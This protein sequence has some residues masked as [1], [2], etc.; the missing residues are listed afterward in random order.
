MSPAASCL[1]VISFALCCGGKVENQ[2]TEGGHNFAAL[3]NLSCQRALRDG[4]LRSGTELGECKENRASIATY[5]AEIGCAQ[6]AVTLFECEIVHGFVCPNP[7]LI[8]RHS[9]CS[10]A[11]A[12]YA[13]CMKE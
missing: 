6:Q 7:P 9:S 1:F 13:E 4:C 10:E 3:A 12:S 8:T 5:A 11:V 2:S